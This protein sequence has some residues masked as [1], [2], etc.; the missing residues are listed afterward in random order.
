MSYIE[1]TLTTWDLFKQA[2]E[3]VITDPKSLSNERRVQL[4]MYLTDP[5]CPHDDCT[6]CFWLD[7]EKERQREQGNARDYG[8]THD[9]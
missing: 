9:A 5:R 6:Y 3:E 1:H 2:M 7:M 8:Q 4:K